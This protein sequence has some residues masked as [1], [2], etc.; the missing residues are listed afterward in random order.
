MAARG[1]GSGGDTAPGAGRAF[2][3]RAG[4]AGRYFASGAQLA[5]HF[6]GS[7]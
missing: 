6:F 5:E 4:E 1:A 3:E 7:A 2:S